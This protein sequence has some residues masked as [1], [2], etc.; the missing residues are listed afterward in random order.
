M[1]LGPVLALAGVA[2]AAPQGLVYRR[3]ANDTVPPYLAS[4]ALNDT[5]P[6][7]LASR[8]AGNANGTVPP[9][10]ASRSVNGTVPP[11]LVSRSAGKSN[12]T[13]PPYLVSRS[14]EDVQVSDFSVQEKLQGLGPKVE[15]IASVNFQLNGNIS[16]NADSPGS[17]GTVFGCGE[18]GYSFGLLNGT[19]SKYS[20]MLYHQTGVAVGR[21][22]QGDIPTVPHAGGSST[23]GSYEINNQVAPTTITISSS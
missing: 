13:V 22:G 3:A 16:C 20:L 11:Y 4:R 15:S 8:S 14:T 1:L 2:A 17:V 18:T 9:Y 12:G 23:N 6:P 21:S 5:V 19:T 7:Y 10:L